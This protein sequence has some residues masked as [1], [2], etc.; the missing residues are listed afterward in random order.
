MRAYLLIVLFLFPFTPIFAQIEELHPC[1]DLSEFLCAYPFQNKVSNYLK[2]YAALNTSDPLE[3]ILFSEKELH[4]TYNISDEDLRILFEEVKT[5]MRESI[6]ELTEVNQSEKLRLTNQLANTHFMLFGSFLKLTVPNLDK[7]KM[8]EQIYKY[9]GCGPEGLE[10][11]AF[12]TGNLTVFCP[13][14]IVEQLNQGATEKKEI[15]LGLSQTMGHELGHLLDKPVLSGRYKQMGSCYDNN[16]NE[17]GFWKKFGNE[18]FA[19]YWGSVVLAKMIKKKKPERDNLIRTLARHMSLS[20][21]DNTGT[22]HPS[23]KLRIELMFKSNQDIQE[24]LG[25]RRRKFPSCIPK[26][27]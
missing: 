15:L 25:C 19:D 6:A 7:K 17:P 8:R 24:A 21:K 18:S 10:R 5:L 9:R 16:L 13:G 14:L 27:Y 1:R 3:R 23:G 12:Q 2:E 26:E 4:Q 11:N 20:C 22:K